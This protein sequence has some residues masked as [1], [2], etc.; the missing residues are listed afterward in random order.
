MNVV[1]TGATGFIG[2]HVLAD[3]HKHGHEVTA[4]VRDDAQAEAV[5]VLEKD[6]T[7]YIHYFVSETGE[8]AAQALHRICREELERRL[9]DRPEQRPFGEAL[10]RPGLSLIAE[11]K[12][13]SPSAGEIRAGVD[14]A[15]VAL[16][17]EE[18]ASASKVSRD[19]KVIPEGPDGRFLSVTGTKLTCFRSLAEALGMS[20]A[21]QR[22]GSMPWLG[23]TAAR[24]LRNGHAPSESAGP[25]R[26]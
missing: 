26:R 16:A 21:L 22:V 7:P 6:P 3:L 18:G 17:Y 1:L 13:R 19:H 2:S 25:H 12:R 5:K 4:L 15:E 23:V 10:V 24:S 9:S 8:S 11:F 20:R 14:P